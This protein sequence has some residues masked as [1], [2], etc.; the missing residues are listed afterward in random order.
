MAA[1]SNYFAYPTEERIKLN[2]RAEPDSNWKPVSD[3]I[4]YKNPTGGD[5]YTVGYAN[6]YYTDLN[7][8]YIYRAIATTILTNTFVYVSFTD[9][10][11]GIRYE[12]QP[13]KFSFYENSQFDGVAIQ[14]RVQKWDFPAIQ[15]IDSDND[16]IYNLYNWLSVLEY[17][18]RYGD[19]HPYTNYPDFNKL[20]L[21]KTVITTLQNA[22]TPLPPYYDISSIPSWTTY[23]AGIIYTNYIRDIRYWLRLMSEKWVE[24]FG[25]YGWTYWD[26]KFQDSKFTTYGY[27]FG[28]YTNYSSPYGELF[29]PYWRPSDYEYES[30]T[31]A[32]RNARFRGYAWFIDDYTLGANP[33]ILIWSGYPKKEDGKLKD[34]WFNP[35]DAWTQKDGQWIGASPVWGQYGYR[36]ISSNSVMLGIHNGT[37]HKL[38]PMVVDNSIKLWHP[39][40]YTKK[41]KLSFTIDNISCS[42]F[43]VLT[44][45]PYTG[46][47]R[48]DNDYIEYVTLSL[49]SGTPVS[50]EAEI[51][52]YTFCTVTLVNGSKKMNLNLQFFRNGDL[53]TYV[54]NSRRIASY[55]EQTIGSNIIRQCGTVIG[56]GAGT[57]T[58]DLWDTLSSLAG[59]NFTN[60]YGTD[61]VGW[62]VNNIAFVTIL[63][64]VGFDAE[65]VVS[66]YV[67]VVRKSDGVVIY[68]ETTYH[69]YP[70]IDGWSGHHGG[71]AAAIRFGGMVVDEFNMSIGKIEL[72]YA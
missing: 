46:V 10:N 32:I 68:E 53:E 12:R 72:Y 37:T 25:S 9:V 58:I 67:R 45:L 52:V 54:H 2:R 22:I 60:E 23:P 4:I 1:I 71:W 56:N 49:E 48:E 44:N 40:D 38:I 43:H 27:I 13:Y 66:R 36:I 17:I 18:S 50:T 29:V 65:L 57:Y 55:N 59:T 7:N 5:V 21:D 51:C 15:D 6:D 19:S 64:R 20:Y 24:D 30:D 11:S 69:S 39:L 33:C 63:E 31:T 14:Q 70:R 42:F 35:I 41:L 28:Y 26:S 16:I 62:I 8:A 47:W 61:R 3:I 34:R